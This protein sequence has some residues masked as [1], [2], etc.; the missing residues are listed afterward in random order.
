VRTNKT[1][2]W[3][4]IP[5]RRDPASTR[6]K[7]LAAAAE[8]FAERGYSG[9]RVER[10]S[11]NAEVNRER[12]Y[13]NFGNKRGLF[14]AVLEDR[15]SAILNS[16]EVTGTG[17]QSL[18]RFAGDYFDQTLAN[19]DL[20][21]LTTWEGLEQGEAIGRAARSSRAEAKIEELRVSAADISPEE[22]RQLFLTIVTLAHGWPA[23]PN[24]AA[25]ILG[26]EAADD[27]RRRA[28][29]VRSISA[30]A[31]DLAGGS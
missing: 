8:E 26:S 17:A 21:R 15:L 27:A 22:V 9:A 19:P 10:I 6:E 28:A 1:F 23:S 5:V 31:A 4:S 20:A 25:V 14:E 30:I 11:A 2:G 13:A 3:Y 12:I 29:I 16:V 7:L 18:A 24:T